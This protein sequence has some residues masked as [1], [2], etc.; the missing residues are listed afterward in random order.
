MVKRF[1]SLFLSVCIVFSVSVAAASD[2]SEVIL[3]LLVKK[4]LITQAEV[5]EMKTEVEKS[6]V[7]MKSEGPKTLEERMANVE[8]DLESKVGLDKLASK[9]KLKGRFAAGYFSSQRAGT[10]FN[11]S[12]RVPEAKLQF[13]FQPDDMNSVIMRM[14]FNNAIANSPLI[15]Y[16]YLDTNVMKLTPWEKSPFK[17]MSRI[18]RLKVDFGEE[19]WSNNPVESAL[20]SN[21]AAN[22]GGYDVGLQLSGKIGK[23]NPV[24]WTAG[25]TNGDNSIGV[26]NNWL[27]AF[28]TKLSYNPIDPLSLSASYYNSGRLGTDSSAINIGGVITPPTNALNWMRQVVEVDAR[29]DFK[30]GKVLN[31][32]A[33]CDSLAYIRLAYGY[34]YDDAI[35]FN[36]G[37]NVR[38]REGNY[39]Y[40]EGLYNL[41]K[42]F[43]TAA[44][45]SYVE[46]NGDNT[47]SFNSVTTKLYERYSFGLGYR[48][49]NA[50]IVKASYDVNLEKNGTGG[51]DPVDGLFSILVSSQF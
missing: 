6:R 22:V 35:R 15:D 42:K 44:R 48:L 21:S 18:G 43:Y 45:A 10:Y 7:T 1:M 23:D 25:I 40:V 51:E 34:F 14:N 36:L 11:N 5:D 38:D 46:L 26:D 33:Y 2:D 39:G 30:K 37:R 17:L 16:L 3:K 13:G 29:Y 41:N 12:F 49:T 24:G 19:T 32:P 20:P 31:P 50:T 28:N 27:K 8:K 4:G 47:A 9:L